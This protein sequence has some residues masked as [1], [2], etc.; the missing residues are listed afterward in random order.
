MVLKKF[1]GLTDLLRG[2]T[3]YIYKKIEVIII[4]ENKNLILIIFLVIAPSF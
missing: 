3:F 1:L 2:L 4:C